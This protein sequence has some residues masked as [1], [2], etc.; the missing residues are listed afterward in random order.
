[1]K[2]REP[3]PCPVNMPDVPSICDVNNVLIVG[4]L[5]DLQVEKILDLIFKSDETLKQ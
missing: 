3:I 4:K 2:K 5:T 1:M